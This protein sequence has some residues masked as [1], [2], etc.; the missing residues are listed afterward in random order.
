MIRIVLEYYYNTIRV[1]LFNV[2]FIKFCIRK[3]MRER[4]GR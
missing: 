1:F 2:T 3:S 4:G